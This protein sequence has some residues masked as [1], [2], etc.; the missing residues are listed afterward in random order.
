LGGRK[1]ETSNPGRIRKVGKKGLL[2]GLEGFI[3][4][5]ISCDK[6]EFV[7]RRGVANPGKQ[8]YVAQGPDRG[9]VGPRW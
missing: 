8:G 2:D 3:M 5:F 1:W 4:P 9:A 7:L 6:K